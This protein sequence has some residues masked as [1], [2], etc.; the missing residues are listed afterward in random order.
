MAEMLTE[1]ATAIQAAARDIEEQ[2]KVERDSVAE[3]TEKLAK[4][5]AGPAKILKAK[6]LQVNLQKVEAKE[7]K[8]ATL[9]K[10]VSELQEQAAEAIIPP[11]SFLGKSARDVSQVL[12]RRD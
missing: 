2:V 8:A 7:K 10:Q 5:P 4:L 11:E 9:Q 3:Q 12:E 1:E 6:A